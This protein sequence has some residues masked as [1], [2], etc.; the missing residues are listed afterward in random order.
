MRKPFLKVW[1]CAVVCM[2][3]PLQAFATI[4]WTD[5]YGNQ[6][7]VE[8]GSSSRGKIALYGYVKISP[9]APCTNLVAGIAPL[10]GTAVVVDSDT[11]VLGWHVI[12]VDEEH[13]CIGYRERYNLDL[14][15]G[16][17]AVGE[18]FF[19]SELPDRIF[20]PTSLTLS[21][22]PSPQGQGNQN[23]LKRFDK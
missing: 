12:S 5:L 3:L 2:L 8:L 9:S 6:I 19:D 13:G 1:I 20:G 22:C 7:S 10:F 18:F 17:A 21:A 15:T 16:N 11:A 4:C 23:P 14:H